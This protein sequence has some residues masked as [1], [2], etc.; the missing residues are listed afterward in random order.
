M[1]STC[2]SSE[3]WNDC[4]S[5]WA[6]SPSYGEEKAEDSVWFSKVKSEFS[7]ISGVVSW[8]GA[9]SEENIEPD[10]SGVISFSKTGVVS[11]C[12]SERTSSSAT[13]KVS[14]SKSSGL[15]S[16]SLSPSLSPS[17]A[18]S[19][20]SAIGSATTSEV[21]SLGDSC[22]SRASWSPPTGSSSDWKLVASSTGSRSF[23]SADSA[24]ASTGS[25][26]TGSGDCSSLSKEPKSG[27]ETSEWASNWGTSTGITWSTTW[28]L[29]TFSTEE[30]FSD[31]SPV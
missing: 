21:S 6:A 30:T 29:S 2:T 18:S 19:S 12:S 24:G 22:D 4:T 15:N 20:T 25:D 7:C 10:A 1:L 23:S 3:G 27:S 26:D 17:L 28:E 14:S 8:T 5:A 9:S 31:P 13:G 16:K 11:S